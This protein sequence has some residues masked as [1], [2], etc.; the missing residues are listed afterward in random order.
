[1]D[2]DMPEWAKNNSTAEQTAQEDPTP[3]RMGVSSSSRPPGDEHRSQRRNTYEAK[4]VGTETEEPH[5]G[6]TSFTQLFTRT[7]GRRL[8]DL[9]NPN[10][11]EEREIEQPVEGPPLFVRRGS[12]NPAS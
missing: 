4:K 8:E 5:M 7:T 9:H 11:I 10:N 12:I 3:I 6:A 2:R 1:M